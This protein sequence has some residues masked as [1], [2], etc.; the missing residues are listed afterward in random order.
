MQRSLGRPKF[1]DY[2]VKNA[3]ID[4]KRPK[5]ANN[6]WEKLVNKPSVCP[7]GPKGRGGELVRFGSTKN[8]CMVA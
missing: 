2:P 5:S 1:E 6:Q 8:K 3:Q 4:E 7:V